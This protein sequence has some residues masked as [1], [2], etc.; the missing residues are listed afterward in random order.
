MINLLLQFRE[1]QQGTK[2][3]TTAVVP[4][5]QASTNGEAEREK[6]VAETQ[7]ILEILSILSQIK[8]GKK[9]VSLFGVV[10]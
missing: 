9:R 5:N 7:T 4:P 2:I 6:A 1:R 3:S 10:Y 8:L